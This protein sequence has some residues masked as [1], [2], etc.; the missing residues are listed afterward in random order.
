MK[1]KAKVV[2]G[3]Y[4]DSVSLMRVAREVLQMPGVEDAA[5]VMATAKNKEI[6]D[7]SGLLLPEFKNAAENDLLICVKADNEKTADAGLAQAETVLSAKTKTGETGAFRPRS[8]AGA[9]AEHPDTNLVLISVPGQYASAEARKTLEAGRH[10]M[11]FSDNVPLEDEIALKQLAA[12]KGLLVMGPD[13]GTAIING[14]PLAFANVVRRGPIGCVAAAGTGL[15]AVT[16]IISNL[17]SGISQ[18]IGT[19][20]RDIKKAVGGLA[21]RTGLTML[22]N[23]PDTRVVVLTAK[24]PDPE[25]LEILSA[26]IKQLGKPVVALFFGGDPEAVRKAGAIPA[27]TLEEAAHLA[28]ALEAGENPEMAVNRLVLHEKNLEETANETSAH[29]APNQKYL[30]GLFCGGT[31]SQEALTLLKPQLGKIH[32]NISPDAALPDAWKS[33]EHTI[34]DLG[35]DEFTVGRP[36]PMIDF[37]LRNRRILEEAADPETAVI[38][39]DVVLGYGSNMQPA[40]ELSPVLMKAMET[41][42]SS[43]RHLAVIVSVTGTPGDP[44]N[45]DHVV[46]TLKTT[47]A[48]VLSST[49]AAAKLAGKIISRIDTNRSTRHE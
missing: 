28:V 12:P 13:C 8:L 3:R 38:L 1:I 20:G 46:N 27:S 25:V 5:V 22:K 40:E 35:E 26:E 39:L 6:V 11:L 36:H 32:S 37:S 7:A 18:A 49:A 33:V 47:S 43:G 19:G 2:S 44:Q 14:V 15:Q 34:V 17:G 9:L 45:M 21:F 48:I 31:F 41:A 24:P 10:V 30:R 4:F 23:D 42:E 16:S 29:L